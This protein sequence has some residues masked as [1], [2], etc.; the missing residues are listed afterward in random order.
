MSSCGTVIVAD[1]PE[2]IPTKAVDGRFTTVYWNICGL[3][4]PVRY[5]LEVAKVEY[6][7][8]RITAGPG[9]PGTDGY[10]KMWMDAKPEVGKAVPF[11]NLPY[12]FDGDS[13]MSQSNAILTYIGRKHG[14]LG[15]NLD[16]V[17]F[18][19]DQMADFDQES[20]GF[21]Y[22]DFS[23]ATAYFSDPARL[24]ARLDSWT[25]YLGDNDYITGPTLTVADLKLYETLR[26]LRVI[27]AEDSVTTK[28]FAS[29]KY[30]KLVAY[31]ERVEGTPALSAY[32]KSSNYI[33]R[34][35]NN[36]HA[37]FR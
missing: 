31:I 7:D 6:V 28:L 32:M 26:K 12:I 19:L 30:A 16:G 34:P 14:L 1:K 23:E 15:S 27:E 4:Q 3:G 11:V 24:P 22:R 21:C 33:A 37:Q 20:T 36:D 35:L 13:A 10:K 17:D 9:V 5:A 25:S 8:V 29:G 18:V 2:A